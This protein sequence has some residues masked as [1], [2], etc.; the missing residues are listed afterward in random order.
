MRINSAILGGCIV[1][2]IV[3]N[4]NT[5]IATNMVKKRVEAPI[6]EAIK[7]RQKT[8]KSEEKWRELRQRLE[9]RLAALEF[10][11][12]QLSNNRDKL[13]DQVTTT[14]KRI[15]NKQKE[16]ADI[17]AISQEM[18]PFLADTMNSL[19]QVQQSDL[20]FLGVERRQRL[21][22][23]HKI[24]ADPEIDV[25]EQYR[26]IMEAL[27]VEA[28]Y[29]L[30]I[31]T[32]QQEI[33]VDGQE[34]LVNIFRLGRLALYYQTLDQSV[35]GFFNVATAQWQPLAEESNQAVQTAIAIAAKQRPAEIISMPLGRMVRQ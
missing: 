23:L 29:G 27:A 30:T 11:V 14:Q 20:P 28:E 31:E 4:N 10:E 26:K 21:Q 12:Q 2:F 3:L 32:Y 19:N 24:V 9:D 33:V 18:A 22:R 34:M 13:T 35:C 5:A 17:R 15:A 1:A 8:Q 16:L 25:S 7:T 6:K